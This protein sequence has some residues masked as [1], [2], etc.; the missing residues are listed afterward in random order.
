M[1]AIGDREGRKKVRRV[2]YKGYRRPRGEK[3]SQQGSV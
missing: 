3:K 1:R 2:A